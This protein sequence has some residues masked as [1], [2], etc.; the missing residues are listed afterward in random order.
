MP[1]TDTVKIRR[2]RVQDS[3]ALAQI[4]VDSYRTSYAGILPRAYLDHFTFDEQEQDWRDLLSSGCDDLLYVA[5]NGAG[6]IGGYA[7]GRP[8]PSEIPPYDGEL[9]ALH[10]RHSFQGQGIG[11]QLIAAV[12]S[13]LQQGGSTALMLWVLEGN[14]AQS[15]YEVLGGRVIGEKDWGGNEAFGTQVKEVAYGWPDLVVLTGPGGE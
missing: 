11:R 14:R 7:L 3:A 8:G 6:E 15:L 4:Q 2:A 5:E 12:A 9:V 1:R 10:V 13:E